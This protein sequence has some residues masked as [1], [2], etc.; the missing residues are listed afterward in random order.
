MDDLEYQK[1]ALVPEKEEVPTSNGGSIPVLTAEAPYEIQYEGV[2][3]GRL[4][5][6]G[7]SEWARAVGGDAEVQARIDEFILESQ[8]RKR[9]KIASDRVRRAEREVQALGAARIA[10]GLTL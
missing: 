5:N 8:E 6:N 3:V 2:R 4:L 7:V 9:R 1:W 10:L